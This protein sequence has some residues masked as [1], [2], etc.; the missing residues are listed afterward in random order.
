MTNQL[1]KFFA[2]KT[3]PDVDRNTFLICNLND[4]PKQLTISLVFMR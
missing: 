3:T 4:K 1:D 2:E